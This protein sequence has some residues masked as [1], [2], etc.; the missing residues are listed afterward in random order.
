[1]FFYVFLVVWCVYFCVIHRILK[2]LKSVFIDHS[3]TLLY[4]NL[5]W[6]FLLI[7]VCN[8]T[9]KKPS[10][11]P[12]SSTTRENP[13][14]VFHWNPNS[15]LAHAGIRI[16]YIEALNLI[17]KY[18]LI[19]IAESAL[20]KSNHDDDIKLNGFIPIRRDLPDN[21]THGGVLLYFRDCLAVRD[22]AYLE[23]CSNMLICEITHQ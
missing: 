21:T 22:R 1:M 10:P 15:I 16:W 5:W 20:H 3:F 4:A 9:L 17:C 8:P 12:T 18:D 19:A 6:I 23:T 13:L 14:K 2:F 7:V 11:W